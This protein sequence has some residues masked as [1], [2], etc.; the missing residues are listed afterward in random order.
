[1]YV[2]HTFSSLER[3]VT[4]DIIEAKKLGWDVKSQATLG[5]TT[6]TRREQLSTGISEL[7]D[8]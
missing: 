4:H 6:V 1:M 7:F 3:E 8:F 2:V 5:R